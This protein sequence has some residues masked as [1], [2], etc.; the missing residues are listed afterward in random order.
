M[1]WP[2][3]SRR[4]IRISATTVASLTIVGG[5]LLVVIRS[6]FHDNCNRVETALARDGQ[7]RLVLYVNACEQGWVDLVSPT[8]H[9]VH[10]LTF[11]AWGGELTH[12]GRPVNGPFE[13][14]ANWESAND[15][16][17]SIGTVGKIEQ[18]QTEVNGVHV[19]Y[20]IGSELYK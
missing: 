17:I 18:Q 19:T 11:S 9:R 15:L 10:L 7:G 13:P 6:M 20:H 14:T 8:G 3:F 12:N 4:R 1:N 5:A 2:D 16:R